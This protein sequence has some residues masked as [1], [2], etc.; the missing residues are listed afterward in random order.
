ML[1]RELVVKANFAK[2]LTEARKAIENKAVKL[3]GQ[4]VEDVNAELQCIRLKDQNEM[5]CYVLLEN[6]KHIGE[7]IECDVTTFEIDKT[8]LSFGKK[9][10][11]RVVLSDELETPK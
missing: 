2:S 1:I 9:K 4:V 6:Q 5:L 11:A 10:H 3:N 8:I 7:D